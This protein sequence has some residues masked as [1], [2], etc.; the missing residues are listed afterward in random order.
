MLAVLLFF[1]GVMVVAFV[2]LWGLRRVTFDET[3]TEAT[4]R[5]S[6]THLTYHVP[7]GQDPAVLSAAL[8][9]AGFRSVG[10][11]QHGVEQLLV[12]CPSAEDRARVRSILEH[13]T[14]TSFEGAELH[15]AHVR[16]EDEPEAPA[17]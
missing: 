3:K 10:V 9:G 5:E 7:D 1:L 14:R 8:A 17:A 2:F 13:V 16:F 4:L 12:D 15:V 6:A 11:L